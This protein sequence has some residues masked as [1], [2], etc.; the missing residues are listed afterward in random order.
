MTDTIKFEVDS[1]GVALLTIDMPDKS[2]NVFNMD[3]INDLETCVD[4]VLE[5]DAIKGA[6]VLVMD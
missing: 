6:G 2:M 3:L 1:D 5:D 4:R